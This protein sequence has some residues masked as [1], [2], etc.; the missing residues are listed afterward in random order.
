[1]TDSPALSCTDLEVAL[2]S[3]TILLPRT[4]LSV[5]AGQVVALTGA[6][7]S[8]KTTLLRAAL[9][10]L[11]AAALSSGRID[12]LG[13]DVLSL[14]ARDLQDLRRSRIG[15]VGQDPGAT[16][17]PRMT[18][19]RL[20]TET[21]GAATGSSAEELLT[22]CR[23]PSANGLTRRRPKAISGGQQRRVALARALAREPR[24]LLLDAPTAGMDSAL[25]DSI[26]SLLRSL[27][28]ERGIA[29]VMT[30]H[31]PA[32]IDSCADQVIAL[33]GATGQS[34]PGTTA[35]K[36]RPRR[37]DSAP[38]PLS[39]LAAR[40]IEVTFGKGARRHRPLDDVDLTVPPGSAIGLTGPSGT[41]KSLLL[42]VLAGLHPAA[43]GSVVLDGDQLAPKARRRDRSQ[44]R[45]I[46]LVPQDPLSALNPSRTVGATLQRPLTRLGGTARND[47]RARVGALLQQVGLPADAVSR[48]PAQ[49]SGGQRQR[50]SI[51]RALAADP[52]YLLCDEITSALD[53]G[54]AI[55]IMNLLARLR[56]ERGMALLVVS[57]QLDLVHAYTDETHLLSHGRTTQLRP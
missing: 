23:L 49:L 57:H 40:T 55:E 52:D 2:P 54:T 24:L 51:A 42:R 20:V 9:G 18:V 47:V 1:M 26:S 19:R 48:Y 34:A 10:H 25:R 50:V 22:L 5:H 29:I 38:E 12:V 44:Q 35:M 4:S 30:C 8:G 7:G 28:A 36:H 43:A 3:G 32:L 13:H 53:P 27:A 33:T 14:P 41:G 37:P 17:N 56:A 15:Y 46:Q 45:R 16:L 6:S 21:R 11:P 39:G 31:D